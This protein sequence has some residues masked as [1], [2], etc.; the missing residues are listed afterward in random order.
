MK[1]SNM[2]SSAVV[3]IVVD[4]EGPTV[5]CSGENLVSIAPAG[6]Y[7]VTLMDLPLCNATDNS[8]QTDFISWSP[9]PGSF[10]LIGDTMVTVV[11]QDPSGN[12]GCG[13]FTVTVLAGKFASS[14]HYQCF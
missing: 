7:G 11:Y 12:T 10:F 2:F 13:S 14:V 3:F 1:H 5:N 9:S 8:G 4:N 6:T